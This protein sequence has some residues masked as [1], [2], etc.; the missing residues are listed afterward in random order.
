[1]RARRRPED[2]W[3][4][5]L[6]LGAC[7][8]V[9]VEAWRQLGG[10]DTIEWSY[11]AFVVLTAGCV[12]L[13]RVHP[14]VATVV[15]GLLTI[16]VGTVSGAPLTSA[17]LAQICLFSVAVRRTRTRTLI[18]AVTLAALLWF[19]VLQAT[20]DSVLSTPALVV[21]PWTGLVVGAG[22]AVR[23]NRDYV[24]ALE[25]RA[26]ATHAAR[27]SETTRR[28]ADERVRIARDLHDA[29]AHTIAVVNVHAGAAEH[30]LTT[31]PDRARSSLQEVRHASRQVL[32]ELRDIVTVLRAGDEETT[33]AL[34]S[35]QGVPALL[36]GART[37]GLDV[38][39]VTDARLDGLEPAV[40]AAL[41][42]VLQEALT[43]AQRHGAGTVTV[44]ILDEPGGIGLLVENAAAPAAPDTPGGF[45][46]VGMRERVDRAG[47]RLEARQIGELFRVRAW[48][49]RPALQDETT[50]TGDAP[51]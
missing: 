17:V 23:A 33:S 40:D 51:A 8:V 48:L 11:V 47:G 25:E 39:A 35:A 41:Y 10:T 46:L 45:G 26:A 32:H 24:R 5:A 37:M 29:V 2:L 49:P 7:A 1:M 3:E 18:T 21:L 44:H 19:A 22:L 9:G 16:L 43:N 4:S 36:T 12:G 30:Q 31:D 27:E 34:A 28:V 13:R 20:D 14:T 50:T 42:R 38:D 6:D 15:A